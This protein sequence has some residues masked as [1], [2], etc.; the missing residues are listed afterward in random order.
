MVKFNF[1]NQKACLINWNHETYTVWWQFIDS[2]TEITFLG[3]FRNL[4]AFFKI[5]F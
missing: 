3:P 1:G 2:L 5:L 4:F